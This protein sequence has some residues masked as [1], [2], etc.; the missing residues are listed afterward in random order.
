LYHSQNQA[1]AALYEVDIYIEDCGTKQN[2]ANYFK[3]AVLV[4]GG[5]GT[6]NFPNGNLT[7]NAK[8]R[9]TRPTPLTFTDIYICNPNQEI[10]NV[11]MYVDGDNRTTFGLPLVCNAAHNF[12]GKNRC[13]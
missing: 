11:T 9:D 2:A 1:Y 7:L 13:K 4:Y 5:I 6:V 12:K 8:I 3:S 10:E